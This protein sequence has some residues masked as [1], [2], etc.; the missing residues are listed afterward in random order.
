M[1][2]RALVVA[3]LALAVA[4]KNEAPADKPVTPPPAEKPA[5]P[6]AVK[7]ADADCM[8]KV[9]DGPAA[10]HEW[11]GVTWEQKGSSVSWNAP[12]RHTVIIGAVTDIKEASEDNLANLKAFVDWFKAQKVDLIVVDGDTGTTKEGIASAITVL[13]GAEVPVFVTIGNGEGREAYKAAMASMKTTLANVFDLVNVRYIHTPQADLVSLPGYFDA[14]YL[15]AKDGCA[16]YQPDVDAT[17][18]IVKGAKAPVVIVSHGGPLQS[19]AN[20][21]DR[22]TEDKHV[23]DPMLAKLIRDHN[24]PFGIFGNVHEAG[25]HATDV[26]GNALIAQKTPSESLFLNPGPSDAVGWIMNDKSESV[27]MA[28]TLTV[29]KGKASYE[30]FR[31]GSAVATKGK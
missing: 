8:G 3:G 19:G 9:T 20:A 11:K 24:I 29:S 7:S 21:V 28:A 6:A 13:A 12:E 23:G 10:T 17:A 22:T 26:D 2:R 31:R 18:A 15:H 4:C 16:Y 5:E 14:N 1:F 27:G 30:I 25:G